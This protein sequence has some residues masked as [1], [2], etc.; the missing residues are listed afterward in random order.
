[1]SRYFDLEEMLET[2][3]EQRREQG[4]PERIEDPEAFRAVARLVFTGEDKQK[5]RG[6]D[7]A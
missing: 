7:A 5:R 4:L 6:S 2:V 1:M 3:R